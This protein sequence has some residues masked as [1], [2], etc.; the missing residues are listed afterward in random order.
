MPVIDAHVHL[1]P[2]EINRDPSG[3][4]R[5]AGESAWAMMSTRVR[6][7]GRPVQGFPSDTALLHAMDRAG[8]ERSVLLGW[9]WEKAKSCEFQNR[10]LARTIAAHPDRFSALAAL[11]PRA[12]A[13]WALAELARVK[14]E[15]FAGLGELCP[16]AQGYRMDGPELAAVLEAAAGL[17]VNFHVTDPQGRPYPGR[18]ETPLPEFVD[19]ARR[20][21]DVTVILA[22]WGGLLPFT[23]AARPVLPSNVYYDT[24]ASPLLYDPSLWARFVAAVGPGKVLFGSDY[25][26]EL[27]PAIPGRGVGPLLAE[28]RASGLSEASLASILYGSAKRL[29]VQ[30]QAPEAL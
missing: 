29:I 26:L 27:Y 13:A 1:Y 21:P 18:I 19:L 10:F 9:Y 25:P 8:V 14:S 7:N 15:G 23:A 28:A 2:P 22:H 11:Q 4:A 5:D 16:P 12:G 24:A 17:A 6:K 3:W 20:H 30:R